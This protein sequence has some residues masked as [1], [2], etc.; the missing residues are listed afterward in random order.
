MRHQ[1]FVDSRVSMSDKDKRLDGAKHGG[2]GY[3]VVEYHD[4][5]LG[6][7]QDFEWKFDSMP[8]TYGMVAKRRDAA[9]AGDA[10]S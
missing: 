1:Q 2:D 3:D 10:R 9:S 8:W 6:E 4:C 7:A 5:V